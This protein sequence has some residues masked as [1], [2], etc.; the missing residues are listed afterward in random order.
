MKTIAQRVRGVACAFGAT[1]LTLAAAAHAQQAAEP[2]DA[3]GLLDAVNDAMPDPEGPAADPEALNPLAPAP[4]PDQTNDDASGFGGEVEVSEYDLVDLHVNNENLGTI[5]QLLS[6]QSERNI[7]TS[8][9]VNATVT[10]DL[11]GVT[12]YEA[13]DAILHA[14]GFGYLERGNFIYVYTREELEQIERASRLPVSRVVTL[15]YLN[16]ADAAEFAKQL[17]SEDGSITTHAATESFQITEGVPAGA[18]GY[19]SSAQLVIHDHADRVEQIVALIDE[20]DTRP[21]QVLIEATILQTSLTEANAFG[22]DFALIKNLSFT[23][24]L[25]D[26]IGGPL[27]VVNGLISGQGQQVDGTDVGVTDGSSGAA[28]QSTP[29]NTAGPATL[30]AG[31]VNDDVGVFL[32]VLDQVT[33]VTVVSNPKI[34]TLNRQPARVLVGTRVGYLNTT[35]TETST[36]Q[37]VEFLDVGTELAVRPFVSKSGLIRLE[38]RPK[39]SNFT[40]REITDS[41]GNTVTIPDEDTSEMTTNVMLTDGQTVVLGGLF[42]ETTT[43][44]RRQ[45]PL[46]GDIPIVGAAFR[47]HDDDTRRNEIIFMI[48]PSL[49]NDTTLATQGERA[50]DNLEHARYGAR[51]GL[52]PWSRERR[53]GQLLIDARRLADEG[54]VQSA[55]SKIDRALYLMPTS[56]DARALRAELTGVVRVGPSHSMLNDIIEGVI[57]ERDHPPAPREGGD[58]SVLGAPTPGEQMLNIGLPGAPFMIP[59]RWPISASDTDADDASNEP[60]YTE[61][62]TLDD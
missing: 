13:L 34:L 44:T 37:T 57:I 20:L 38:L 62:P 59:A 54:R 61:V 8:S 51:K 5:L 27:N 22:V 36:T 50:Q 45:V 46:L 42:T 7:I 11:Y 56:R 28:A 1:M 29:G 47:G 14:N 24:F 30:K 2:D 21:A 12:F 33:D 48:T 3:F 15:D 10:A 35:T 32:R 55:L 60:L 17:L 6:I 23:D 53:V 26:D 16:A 49:V 4:T 58:L 40:L 25:G 43:A 18:D 41:L 52:L 19:A 31:I 39:V 9:G